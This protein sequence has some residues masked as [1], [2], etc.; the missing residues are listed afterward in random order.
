MSVPIRLGLVL[1]CLATQACAQTAPACDFTGPT[2]FPEMEATKAAFLAGDFDKFLALSTADMPNAPDASV[3]KS[4]VDLVPDGFASCTTIVQ[5][6][7]VG[8]FVQEVSLFELPD[9]QGPI[10]LY[11]RSALVDGQ[12]RILQFTFNSTMSTV[13]DELR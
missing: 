5:R 8:G 7:D 3:M 12:R 13:L 9:G 2:V 4:L 10:S 6:E 1:S 11:I